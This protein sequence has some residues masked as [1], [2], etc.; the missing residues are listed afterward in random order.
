MA[1]SALPPLITAR[2]SALTVAR[3]ETVS[4]AIGDV[5]RTGDGLSATV[6]VTSKV[7]HHFPSGVGFRRAFLEVLV[8][9]DDPTQPLWASGRTNAAGFILDGVGDAPLETE[10]HGADGTRYQSHHQVVASG[11]EAQIYE[12]VTTD[13]AGVV[14]TSFLHRVQVEK[15]NR[16]RPKGWR[17]DGPSADVTRPRGAEVE[18]DPDYAADTLTG[19]DVTAYTVEL[20]P[21]ARGPLS[22]RA[23]V[24]YQAIP[25][26]YLAHRF[27]SAA[28]G[29]RSADGE[30][31]Y[32]MVAHLDT[33]AVA[34]DGA[35]Y[36]A[37]WKL[38][39]GRDEVT[40]PAP[41]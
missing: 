19:S 27:A 35:P 11:A 10:L 16:I 36:L 22:L 25:P 13:S 39:V 32:Y 41:R 23:T 14:T 7:G 34:E 15:D 3:E 2:E 24:Y 20:P 28:A 31:L 33:D 5:V 6:T 17:R 12:E 9:R 18:A 29:P 4:V 21:D 1:P 37:G 30:R 26:Y 40:V 8:Y 38:A